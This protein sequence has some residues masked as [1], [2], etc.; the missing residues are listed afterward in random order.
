[1]RKYR[2]PTREA[3]ETALGKT[4]ERLSHAQQALWCVLEQGIWA[5]PVQVSN[6]HYEALVCAPAG[7][8]GGTVLLRWRGNDGKGPSDCSA[9]WSLDDLLHHARNLLSLD[10]EAFALRELAEQVSAVRNHA[11][12]QE[13][14]ERLARQSA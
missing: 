10:D 12:E 1:M 3:A 8:S 4:E 2:Y 11:Y 13:Q 5:K 9:V 6:K 14:Q 7:A